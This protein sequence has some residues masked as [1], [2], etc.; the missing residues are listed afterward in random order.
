MVVRQVGTLQEENRAAGA[1]T[2]P[3]QNILLKLK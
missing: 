3:K 2:L 1:R